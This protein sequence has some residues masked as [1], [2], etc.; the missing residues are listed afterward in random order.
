VS[1][2]RFIQKLSDIYTQFD[3]HTQF[4][5]SSLYQWSIPTSKDQALCSDE[6]FIE[7]IKVKYQAMKTFLMQQEAN[8]Q[9]VA[10]AIPGSVQPPTVLQQ[11]SLFFNIAKPKQLVESPS[12]LPP[13]IYLSYR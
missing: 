10:D 7:A 13:V 11:P 9:A 12:S 1:Y 3:I 6:G 4:L 8:R 2:E 5:V